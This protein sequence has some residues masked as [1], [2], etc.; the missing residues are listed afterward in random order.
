MVARKKKIKIDRRQHTCAEGSRAVIARGSLPVTACGS[1][2]VT[3]RTSLPV[4]EY[5]KLI[6]ELAAWHRAQPYMALYGR[7]MHEK[8]S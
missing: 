2:P 4:T 5:S 1:L 7:G 8:P 3:G 6:T